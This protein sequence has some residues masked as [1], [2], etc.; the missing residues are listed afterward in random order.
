MKDQ[1]APMPDIPPWP[2]QI[3]ETGMQ[4]LAGWMEQERGEAFSHKEKLNDPEQ[5]RKFCEQQIEK[6]KQIR[7]REFQ[8][9]QDA[10]KL[11]PTAQTFLFRLLFEE[12]IKFYEK[13]RGRDRQSLY[14]WV[15]Q[16]AIKLNITEYSA[17]AVK[18]ICYDDGPNGP[19]EKTVRAHLRTYL[20]KRET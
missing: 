6:Y 7:A 1:Q 8:E 9:L 15:E 17:G 5:Y 12:K 14:D 13:E 10:K 4:L 3:D 16:K 19:N 18:D 20:K 2:D 11:K